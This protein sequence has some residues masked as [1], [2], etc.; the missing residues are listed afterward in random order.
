MFRTVS[1]PIIMNFFTVHTVIGTRGADKSL[2]RSG[3][4]QSRKHGRDAC[5][6]NKIETRAVIKFLF[7]HGKTPK[8]IHA[9]LTEKL[10]CF[11]P[12]R[13]K[14]FSAPLYT[15]YR[16]C[17]LFASGILIQLALRVQC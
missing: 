3:R 5:D 10:P 17:W 9:I 11:L 13:P 12:G 4:K 7:L 2:A 8:D 16:L 1:L 14:D 6:F 15:S